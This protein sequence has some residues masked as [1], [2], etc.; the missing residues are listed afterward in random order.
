MAYRS[1]LILTIC[2]SAFFVACTKT[3]EPI[4]LTGDYNVILYQINNCI[5]S[6]QN[7]KFS[8]DSNFCYLDT[9]VDEERCISDIAL[10]FTDEVYTFSHVQSVGSQSTTV[11][12]D[13]NYTLIDNNN[14]VFCNPECENV[15][16]VLSDSLINIVRSDT[17][18]GC[19]SLIK[20]IR[21]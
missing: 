1:L 20:A 17:I 12:E 15:L 13:G 7:R 19:G 4:S 6:T 2:I 18:S 21:I 5:D 11:I 10:S 14:F 9:F 8:I 3:P 16:I